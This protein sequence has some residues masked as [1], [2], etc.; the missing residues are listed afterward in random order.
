[1]EKFK[2]VCK[3]CSK[4]YQTHRKQQRYCGLMCA[5][6]GKKKMGFNAYI[7]TRAERSAQIAA[8]GTAI[9]RMKPDNDMS[10]LRL[11]R[12]SYQE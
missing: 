10:G 7:E 3:Q 1:M 9:R 12:E 6:K 4:E 8:E 11:D 2:K 5:Y